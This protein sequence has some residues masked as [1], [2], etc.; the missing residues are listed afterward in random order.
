MDRLFQNR[1]K[2]EKTRHFR[3]PLAHGQPV[4]SLA[5]QGKGKFMPDAVHNNLAVRIL[6]HHSNAVKFLV[7]RVGQAM[8]Q[9]RTGQ[10]TNRTRFLFQLPQQG[11]F[12]AASPA[13]E[14]H[15]FT[16]LYRQVNIG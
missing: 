4:E 6:E 1:F 2:P 7:R 16:R 13:A 11:S 15:K 5:F 8:K 12:S 9:N 3:N 14:H 10:R